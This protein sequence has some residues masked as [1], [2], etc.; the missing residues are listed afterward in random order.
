[1]FLTFDNL[2]EV[3]QAFI[4]KSDYEFEVL[5]MKRIK[6]V[7]KK[8]D[9]RCTND[10]IQDPIRLFKTNTVFPALDHVNNEM[11]KRF[12]NE[13]SQNKIK[14]VNIRRPPS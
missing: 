9:E 5:R 14:I 7:P 13:T 1:M 2:Y 10:R 6:K 8:H 12:K 3:V 11:N 4:D